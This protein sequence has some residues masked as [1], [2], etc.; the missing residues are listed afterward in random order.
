MTLLSFLTRTPSRAAVRNAAPAVFVFLLLLTIP[1]LWDPHSIYPY[2]YIQGLAFSFGVLVLLAYTIIQISRRQPI[3]LVVPKRFHLWIAGFVTCALFSM[4]FAQSR[5]VAFW[6]SDI[7][8]QG[9]LFLLFCVFFFYIITFTIRPKMLPWILMSLPLAGTISNL[10]GVAQVLNNITPRAFASFGHANF[11]ASFLVATIPITLYFF[12]QKKKP[13]LFLFAYFFQCVGLLLTYSRA[14]WIAAAFG[15]LFLSGIFV[16]KLYREHTTPLKIFLPLIA[17]AVA[18]IFA[19]AGVRFISNAAAGDYLL[20]SGRESVSGN[21]LDDRVK[22]IADFSSGSGAIRVYIWKDSWDIIRAYPIFGVGPDNMQQV[23]ARFYRDEPMRPD[24]S[25]NMIADRA[26]N[27]ILDTLISYGIVGLIFYAGIVLTILYYALRSLFR[28]SENALLLGALTASLVGL[29]LNNQF[30]FSVTVTSMLFWTFLAMIVILT[31][32]TKNRPVKISLP[33]SRGFAVVGLVFAFALSLRIAIFPFLASHSALPDSDN[34]EQS[35]RD[36]EN[37]IALAPQEYYYHFLLASLYL[38]Q[39]LQTQ[40]EDQASF[41]ALSANELIQAHGRG[42]DDLTFYTSLATTYEARGE[43]EL[44]Y[45]MR[46]K[47]Q[48]AAPKMNLPA[49]SRRVSEEGRL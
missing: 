4:L 39:G 46:K 13:L 45:E 41:F 20:F 3:F 24:I 31:N 16:R 30:G 27:E 21:P 19:Y 9:V 2:E 17:V 43:T 48:Q 33:H 5:N 11:F 25:R 26:H 35:T 7:R 36:L 23:Y 6:G 47:A 18:T 22:N 12:L 32:T 8:H 49:A 37:A 29:L 1:M 28:Q 15:I 42:L 44:F 10:W 38:D 40:G 14:G 34:S